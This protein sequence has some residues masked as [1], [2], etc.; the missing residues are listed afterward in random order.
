MRSPL[1]VQ[2]G[3]FFVCSRHIR[4]SEHQYWRWLPQPCPYAQWPLQC[5]IQHLVLW[6]ALRSEVTVVSNHSLLLMEWR[7]YLCVYSCWASTGLQYAWQHSSRFR[8]HEGTGNAH[9]F[10]SYPASQK[11]KSTLSSE[12]SHS[13]PAL[14]TLSYTLRIPFK[15]PL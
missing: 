6:L 3:R 8:F 15:W 9:V 1:C 10:I 2:F 11:T 14:S 4:W 13:H 7:P 5:Y 12:A